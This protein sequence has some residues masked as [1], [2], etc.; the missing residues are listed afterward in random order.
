LEFKLIVHYSSELKRREKA[1][2]KA[3]E[4]AAK[5]AAKSSKPA[6]TSTKKAEE[7]EEDPTQYFENRKK[8]LESLGQNCYPHKFHVSISVPEFIKKYSYLEKD[9]KLDTDEVTIAGKSLQNHKPSS[10]I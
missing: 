1:Q 3:E 9:S 5:E 10:P 7:E 4:K 2:K 8:A 6:A